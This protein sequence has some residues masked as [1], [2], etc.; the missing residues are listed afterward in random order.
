[1]KTILLVDGMAFVYR[2]YFAV[3]P[4]TNIAGVHTNAVFGFNRML[5]RMI[6]QTS[7]DYI[8]VLFDT[9]KPTFRHVLFPEYK[10]QR[11][12]M[13]ADLS[14]Q[15]PWIKELV[16]ALN[17]PCLE[18]P[19]YEA[20]DIIGTL[21][22]SG[23]ENNINVLIASADKDL[24]QLVN[25]K[26]AILSVTMKSMDVIDTTGV[27]DKFG[28]RP[29]Q[30]IDYLT[31][32]GDTADNVPGVKKV[33]CKTAKLLLNQL[34]S[35]DNIYSNLDKLKP[36]VKKSFQEASEKINAY[37]DLIKIDCKVPIKEKI[38]NLIMR[39]PDNNKFSEIIEYLGFRSSPRKKKVNIQPE[40]F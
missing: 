13:P 16:R 40:L 34:E 12:P 3:P 9:P 7:P 31:L 1:V 39:E 22:V 24:C 27:I 30:V 38:D 18:Y 5:Q 20:D 33:G 19:G 32:V 29:D 17:I 6:N 15:I 2:A 21:A 36:A 10:A 25:D 4:M 35:I 11:P 28:V 14:E 8:A 26:I 37:R 23:A